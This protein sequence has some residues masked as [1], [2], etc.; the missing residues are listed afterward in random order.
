MVMVRIRN[1]LD[2]PGA[3]GLLSRSF[4]LSYCATLSSIALIGLVSL[5]TS[6]HSCTSPHARSF[7]WQG[8]GYVIPL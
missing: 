5:T 6:Y 7:P 1:R 4:L 8:G 3:Y 2:R